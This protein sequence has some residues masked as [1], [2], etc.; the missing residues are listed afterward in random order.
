[1]AKLDRDAL[2]AAVKEYVGE[3]TSDRALKLIEDLADTTEPDKEDWKQKY[4]DN[5]AAW[6]Q[7]YKD[8]FFSGGPENESAEIAD[9]VS[10]ETIPLGGEVE[11]QTVLKYED[12]FKEE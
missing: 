5:D 11:E 9:K 2:L 10:R 6:R 12:L 8:R 3:D 1:M 4:L 7:R